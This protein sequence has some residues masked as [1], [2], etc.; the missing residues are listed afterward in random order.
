MQVTTN[1]LD[2]TR[3]LGQKIGRA[4]SNPT[5][6]ALTGDLGS[7]KT[8]LVQGIANGLDVSDDYYITSPTYTF[9]N[10]YPGRYPL[11]HVDLYRVEDCDDMENIGF[12]EILVADAIV[13]V[14]WADRVPK[15]FFRADLNICFKIICDNCRMITIVPCGNKAVE[16]IERLKRMKEIK[17]D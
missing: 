1:C 4:F 14:E 16:M 10:E 15:D 17:W 11:F 3:S 13:A 6:I 7:G 2:E 9:I 12:D 5:V 8:S